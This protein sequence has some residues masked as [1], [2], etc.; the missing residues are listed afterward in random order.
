MY[1]GV[2]VTLDWYELQMAANVGLARQIESLRRGLHDAH[3]LK[4]EAG[5]NLHIEGAAGEIAFAKAA[6]KY[7]G[8]SVNT[9][10]DP[11]LGG[12]IQIRTRSGG[13]RNSL[14]VRPGDDDQDIFVLVIGR[15]PKFLVAGWM[16]GQV[17]KNQAWMQTYGGRPA[18]Y[19]VPREELWPLPIVYPA[20]EPAVDPFDGAEA[21]RVEE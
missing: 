7:W 20:Q 13:V 12:R 5:W 21:F 17:A 2:E 4:D 6:G 16:L 1:S 10:K 19:F 18:A 9:F 8:G 15:S 11:D 14:I 3:G